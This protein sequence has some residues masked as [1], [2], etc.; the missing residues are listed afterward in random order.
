MKNITIESYQNKTVENNG[1][2][3]FLLISAIFVI[4]ATFALSMKIP[5]SNVMQGYQYN[6]LII[7]IVMD[8]FTK[9]IASTGIMEFIGSKIALLT[10]GNKKLILIFFGVLM[11]FISAFVNNITAVMIVLP[12]IFILL[13]GINIDQKF[14]YVFFAVL[15]A[16]SNTGGAASP[17]GDFPAVIIMTSGITT[18]FD[19]LIRAMPVFILTSVV[20]IYF[21]S[22]KVPNS[23]DT[24]EKWAGLIKGKKYDKVTLIPLLVVFVAMFVVWSVVPQNIMP[25]EIV[26]VLGYGIVLAI[27]TLRK[28]VIETIIDFKAVLT[29]AGF[30]FIASVISETGWLVVIANALQSNITDPKIL[31]LVIMIM[32]SAMSGLFSAGPAAAA[33]MPIIIN[34]CNT[35]LTGESHWVAI[36]YAASICAGSSLFMWSATAGFILSTKIDEAKLDYQW[37]IGAYLKFGLMNYIIQMVIAIAIIAII[38]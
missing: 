16:I 8:L 35:A 26:A 28:K 31:L 37:G 7:L 21:W 10:R 36:A 2:S 13:R 14:I 9:L 32:T 27:C 24:G 4:G 17:I 33:M 38:I 3:S 11:F 23:K 1:M 34:L 12:I 18:F 15:L 22:L 20:L 5:I 6:V 19:Y 29:I 25:P 30:L